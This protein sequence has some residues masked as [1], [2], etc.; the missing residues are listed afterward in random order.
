MGFMVIGL[1][2]RSLMGRDRMCVC[3]R[4]WGTRQMDVIELGI[5]TLSSKGNQLMLGIFHENLLI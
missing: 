3:V 2:E 4:K 1:V 5:W